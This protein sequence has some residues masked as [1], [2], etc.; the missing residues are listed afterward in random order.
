MDAL[1]ILGSI[2]SIGGAI[3]AWRKASLASKSA[4][5]AEQMK[6]EILERRLTIELTKIHTKTSHIL[7]LVGKIGPSAT[8]KTLKGVDCQIIALE[9]QDFMVFIK[10]HSNLFLDN[11]EHNTAHLLCETL[12]PYIEELAYANTFE[13]KKEVGKQVFYTI[14][15]FLPQVKRLIDKKQ[16]LS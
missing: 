7:K 8:N 15:N 9:L 2:A 4:S 1:T 11:N 6:N 14:N 16:N 12:Q 10:E 3:W 5:L 13:K